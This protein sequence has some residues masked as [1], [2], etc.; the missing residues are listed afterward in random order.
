L[1][2]A[3]PISFRSAWRTFLASSNIR[4]TLSTPVACAA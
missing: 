4:G 2:F 3:V 1:G